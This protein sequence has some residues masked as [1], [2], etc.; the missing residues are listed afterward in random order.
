MRTNNV[1]IPIVIMAAFICALSITPSAIAGEVNKGGIPEE[2]LNESCKKLPWEVAVWDIPEAVTNLK[3]DKKILWIDT[4][5]ATLFNRGTVRDA[6]LLPYDKT[7]EPGNELTRESLEA[8][9]TAKN[10]SKTD[11]T[12]VFFCQ[13]PKC[14]RSYNATFVAVTQWGVPPE[15]VVWF[16][17]GYPLLLKEVRS[18][19][20]MK[21]KAKRYIS[22]A[23]MKNL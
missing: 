5:P 3:S 21:R 14:H 18:D 16:R 13:G 9:L 7:G 10:F 15:N 8:S 1:A 23:G 12:I 20:K 4:R 2:H 19:P 6:I 22:D 11:A 17:S